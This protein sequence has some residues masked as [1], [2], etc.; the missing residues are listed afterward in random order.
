LRR[1]DQHVITPDVAKVDMYKTS[2]H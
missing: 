2:G 1:G